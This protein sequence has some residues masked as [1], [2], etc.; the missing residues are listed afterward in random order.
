MIR[1][2]ARGPKGLE[3]GIRDLQAGLKGEGIKQAALIDNLDYPVQKGW[4]H[5]EIESRPFETP[6][7]FTT[8]NEK[9]TYKISDVGIDKLEGASTYQRQSS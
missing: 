6:K 4:V 9:I 7:G 5:K 1:R 3:T 8:Q 2:K